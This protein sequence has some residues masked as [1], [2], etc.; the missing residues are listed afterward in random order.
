MALV[1]ADYR[2]PD[3]GEL[4]P[5]TRRWRKVKPCGSGAAWRRHQRRGEPQDQA[6]LA[7]RS[8]WDR[9]RPGRG[10]GEQ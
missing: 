10:R 9:S 4:F 1:T 7:W 2:I 5:S 3:I 8:N 6:C